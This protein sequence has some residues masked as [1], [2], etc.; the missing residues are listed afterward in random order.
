MV[1]SLQ[2]DYWMIYRAFRW[3][4]IQGSFA[5]VQAG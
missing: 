5:M 2:G 3:N 1:K 4:W